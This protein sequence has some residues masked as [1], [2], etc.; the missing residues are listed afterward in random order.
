MMVQVQLDLQV[1]VGVRVG[2]R[3][4]V[5]RWTMCG[6]LGASKGQN[7]TEGA[8][9]ML[10]GRGEASWRCWGN[11]LWLGLGSRWR[12]RPLLTVL[13]MS[14]LVRGALRSIMYDSR[15]VGD[16]AVQLARP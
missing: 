11:E 4:W 2:V 6:M 5:H 1:R 10:R 13:R 15:T 14:D 8:A 16:A 3:V 9:Q 12:C 7:E